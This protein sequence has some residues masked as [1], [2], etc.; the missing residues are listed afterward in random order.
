MTRTPAP[1]YKNKARVGNGLKSLVESEILYLNRTFAACG[2][3]VLTAGTDDVATVWNCYAK[4]TAYERG[5][6]DDNKQ[7]PDNRVHNKTPVLSLNSSVAQ[8]MTIAKT[9]M[10]FLIATSTKVLRIGYI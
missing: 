5:K 2:A 8:A 4:F 3:I 10:Q 1:L 9:R 6:D 7:Q